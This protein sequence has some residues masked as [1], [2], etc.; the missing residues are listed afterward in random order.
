M[1]KNDMSIHAA[2]SLNIVSRVRRVDYINQHFKEKQQKMKCRKERKEEKEH[3][4]QIK[5]G[6]NT[7]VLL[8]NKLDH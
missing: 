5:T 7:K 2:L 3:E 6:K 1:H 4:E 8:V